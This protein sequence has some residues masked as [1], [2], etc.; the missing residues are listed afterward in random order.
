MTTTYTVKKHRKNTHPALA[1]LAAGLS[2][3]GASNSH[4]SVALSSSTKCIADLVRRG[5]SPK[6]THPER[7]VNI[8]SKALL[9]R[10]MSE[11]GLVYGKLKGVKA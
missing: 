4:I 9:A 1:T 8:L 5:S 11:W 10:P 6:V 7:G 2:N 3:I